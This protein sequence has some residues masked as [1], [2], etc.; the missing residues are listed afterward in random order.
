MATTSVIQTFYV[1]SQAVNGSTTVVLT[2]VDFFFATKPTATNNASGI[3]NPGVSIYLCNVV[4]GSPTGN[5][6]DYPNSLTRLPFGSITAV[7]D[8]SVASRFSFTTPIP[9][10]SDNNYAIVIMFEDP[11][12]T[13]WTSVQGDAIIGTNNPSPGPS[14]QNDGNFYEYTGSN[15]TALAST[16]LKFI[17]YIAQFT[18]NTLTVDLVNE[19]YEFLNT[20]SINRGIFTSE[21][22]YQ[23]FSNTANVT[24]YCN[25]SLNV[26]NNNVTVIGT[27]TSLSSLFASNDYIVVT[28]GTLGNTNII[29][30]SYV[31]NSTAAVLTTPTLFNNAAASFRKTATANG[32]YYNPLTNQLVLTHSRANSSIFFSNSSVIS[33]VIATGGSG[34]KNTDI[35]TVSGGTLN[36]TAAIT[37]NS[38]GGIIKLNFSNAGYGFV[39]TGTVAIKNSTGGSTSG[40]SAN[41]VAN[42]FGS[43]VTGSI[44][45]ATAQVTQVGDWSVDLFDSSIS[46]I[47]TS[48]ASV[49]LNYDFAYNNSG[50]YFVTTSYANNAN[51]PGLNNIT[52]YN[53]IIMSRS[54]EVNN[55]SNLFNENGDPKSTIFKASYN[56]NA[57]NTNLFMSPI[58]YKDLLNLYTMQNEINNNAANEFLPFGGNA[59]CKHVTTMVTLA[60][61]AEDIRVYVEGWVPAGTQVQAYA[62]LYN[63]NVDSDSFNNKYWSPLTQLS[64]NTNFSSSLTDSTDIIEFVY[65]LPQFPPSSNTTTGLSTAMT[66]CSVINGANTSYNTQLSVG[67]VIKLYDPLFPANNYMVAVVNSIANSTQFTIDSLVL[68]TSIQKSGLLID[69]LSPQFVAFNNVNGDNVS[70]YYTSTSTPVDGFTNFEIK[71]VLLSTANNLAPLISSV[72]AVGV[73]A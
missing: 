72:S 59:V 11:G 29:L 49:L 69:N 35:L 26:S 53:A 21:L 38:S 66:A 17:V 20:V 3:T 68:N 8:A 50:T 10:Q 54:N 43:Y 15:I 23:D 42:Q 5:Q 45:G 52:N 33:P 24:Y 30:I 4:N 2:G 41:I 71:L 62:K 9:V 37:T 27:G 13:L 70:R 55:P 25:G 14:G 32:Y 36:A 51:N 39:S 22:V 67:S 44:T 16:D 40:S 46:L 65:G 57:P 12:Y 31:I 56:V 47:T 63:A 34:Y 19:N 60:A 73:S 58:L 1:S 64:P 7:S 48:S 28:D 61:A 18:A 6:N